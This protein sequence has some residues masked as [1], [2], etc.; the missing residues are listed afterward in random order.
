MSSL[1]RI[2][3]YGSNFPG[4]LD[5]PR[6]MLGKRKQNITYG[7]RKFKKNPSARRVETF[8]GT[9][10]YNPKRQISKKRPAGAELKIHQIG[11]DTTTLTT[12]ATTTLPTHSHF[13]SLV[14][15]AQG[16]SQSTR[17]GNR[18]ILDQ[19][20]I[21]GQVVLDK[22]SSNVWTGA[23]D[24]I[25][26]NPTFRVIV[27]VDTQTNGA[28]AP[29]TTI[30]DDGQA[31]EFAFGVYNNI[32]LGGRFKILMDKWIEVP[33]SSTCFN[34]DHKTY[35]ASTSARCFKKTFKKM[36]LPI[37]Y[38]DTTATIADISSNNVGMIV[39]SNYTKKDSIKFAYRAR[40]RFYDY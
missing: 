38:T 27:Y 22:N 36:N 35:N 17:D 30:F 5:T 33:Q 40:A 32:N 3:Q 7:S 14:L 34:S 12:D 26:G 8:G 28:S 13:P 29:L 21:R 39:M 19:L 1:L 2:N 18:I 37:F 15:V 31:N 10:G 4:T 23:G 9:G 16:D 11:Q 24:V 25:N 6:P 20:T